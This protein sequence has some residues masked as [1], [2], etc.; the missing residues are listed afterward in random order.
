MIAST[1]RNVFR[2]CLSIPTLRNVFRQW[3]DTQS[4]TYWAQDWTLRNPVMKLLCEETRPLTLT[5]WTQSGM[6][7]EKSLES[8]ARHTERVMCSRAKEMLWSNTSNAAH[9]SSK[10]KMYTWPSS[11]LR[12]RQF[13]TPIPSSEKQ[14]PGLD[15]DGLLF[16]C[17]YSFTADLCQ[18]LQFLSKLLASLVLH[19]LHNHLLTS[20]L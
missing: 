10:V 3:W 5:A 9:K 8:P 11:A 14:Q 15:A 7:D 13:V 1:L 2:Q 12:R 19:Q 6:Y 20:N 18:I 17:A 4:K 16:Q